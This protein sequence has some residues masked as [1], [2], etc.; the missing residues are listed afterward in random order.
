MNPEKIGKIIATQRM[1]KHLTQ[2]ELADRLGV[3]NKAVSN[4]ERGRAIPDV[5]LFDSICKELDLTINELL[6]G[7][8]GKSN[9]KG[10]VD[11]LKYYKKYHNYS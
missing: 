11:Y 8:K 2:Q 3:T 10:L 5:G 4:W 6:N 7:E 9:S 1:K